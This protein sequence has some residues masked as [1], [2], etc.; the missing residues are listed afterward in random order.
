MRV[1]LPP[2]GAFQNVNSGTAPPLQVAEAVQFTVVPMACGE[3]GAALTATGAPA[4]L[5]V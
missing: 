4:Q 5:P 2:G 3:A 1:E